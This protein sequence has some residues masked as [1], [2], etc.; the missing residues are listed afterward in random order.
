MILEIKMFNEAALLEM[1]NAVTS[2]EAVL[3]QKI[4]KTQVKP[5]IRFLPMSRLLT[6]VGERSVSD[7]NVGDKIISREKGMVRITNI[8]NAFL[9]GGS[10]VNLIRIPQDTF[11]NHDILDVFPEQELVLKNG[12]KPT[13][14]VKAVAL[15]EAGVASWVRLK[16][17]NLIEIETEYLVTQTYLSGQAVKH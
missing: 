5:C 17:E 8:R 16:M 1:S 14:F 6:N 3:G 11:N 15:A 13:Q 7:L 9:K 10:V 2:V 12:N 4:Q